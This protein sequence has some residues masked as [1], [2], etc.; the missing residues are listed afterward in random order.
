MKLKDIYPLAPYSQSM[1][2]IYFNKY[3]GMTL[4]TYITT[5]KVSY[6]CNLLRYTDDSPLDISSKLSYDSLSHFNRVFKKITGKTPIA[7]RKSARA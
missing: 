1:L 5:L 7:Y 6:A 4:I 2:N 3:V